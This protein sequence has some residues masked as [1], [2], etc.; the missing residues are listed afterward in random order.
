MNLLNPARRRTLSVFFQA[1]TGS[2]KTRMPVA[3][4]LAGA[5]AFVGKFTLCGDDGTFGCTMGNGLL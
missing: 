2:G 5:A 3:I 4:A 1:P